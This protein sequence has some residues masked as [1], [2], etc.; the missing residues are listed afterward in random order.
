MVDRIYVLK[1]GRIA[2]SGTHKELMKES[3]IYAGMFETQAQRYR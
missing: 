1:H 2:E 3:R